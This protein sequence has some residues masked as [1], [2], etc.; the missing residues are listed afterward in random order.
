[1][2]S[3]CLVLNIS[4]DSIKLYIIYDPLNDKFWVWGKTINEDENQDNEFVYK[5]QSNHKK[6]LHTF[7]QFVLDDGL[8]LTLYSIPNMPDKCD[9][10]THEYFDENY[11]C[12]DTNVIT[13]YNK[14]T[15]RKKYFFKLLNMLK[16][17]K[18][19]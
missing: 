1:M 18:N 16:F 14:V 6:Q 5:C 4:D 12:C 2:S 13:H 17:I 15:L 8:N 7:I 19:E 10:I 11:K 9:E 3:D